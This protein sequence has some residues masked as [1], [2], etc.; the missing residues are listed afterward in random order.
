MI[1]GVACVYFDWVDAEIHIPS[2][3]RVSGHEA[4]LLDNLEARYEANA[5]SHT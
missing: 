4:Q 5:A 3:E 2:R 1:C